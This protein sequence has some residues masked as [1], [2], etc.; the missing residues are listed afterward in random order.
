MG[1]SV[2]ARLIIYS[3]YQVVNKEYESKI[4][5]GNQKEK[6]MMRKKLKK[7]RQSDAV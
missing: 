4:E 5:V 1:L 7:W 2:N 6:D 3:R